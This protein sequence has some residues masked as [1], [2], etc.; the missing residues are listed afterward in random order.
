MPGACLGPNGP[1]VMV[2]S[3]LVKDRAHFE[4]QSLASSSMS[5]ENIVF[6]K[7]CK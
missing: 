4:S 6:Y 2:Y 5:N 3:R 7:N 1:S